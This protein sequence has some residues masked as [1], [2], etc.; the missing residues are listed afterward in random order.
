MVHPLFVNLSFQLKKRDD[1]W[2]RIFFLANLFATALGAA[3]A[4]LDNAPVK[5]KG[6]R[7]DNIFDSQ[8]A[9]M[10]KILDK[11]K[12]DGIKSVLKVAGSLDIVG[13]PVGLISNISHGVV[14]LIEKPVDGFL[15]G[16][17]EGGKGIVKGAGSLVKNT[18]AGTF[19]SIGKVTGSIA[20]GFSNL[21]MVA[22]I[23]PHKSLTSNRMTSTWHI[24]KRQN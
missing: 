21:S 20:S 13:N 12:N 10:K 3:I 6:F 11:V 4:N 22:Y 15:Q 16:P 23:L 2:K 8:E 17:L 5:L 1:S 24:E 18:V 19:N 7:L 9:I 14:D